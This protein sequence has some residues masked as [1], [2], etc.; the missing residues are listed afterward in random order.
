MQMFWHG[1]EVDMIIRRARHPVLSGL[2]RCRQ[3]M[4]VLI[5]GA[6]FGGQASVKLGICS[7]GRVVGVLKGGV[8]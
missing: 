4:I 3:G 6:R 2:G 8:L 7:A 5:Q 1:M